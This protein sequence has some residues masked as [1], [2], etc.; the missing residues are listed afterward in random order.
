MP[1]T[2]GLSNSISVT[3]GTVSHAA[4]GRAAT[5][6]EAYSHAKSA[7]NTAAG[8]QAQASRDRLELSDAGQ[9]LSDAAQIAKKLHDIPDVRQD[10]IDNARQMIESGELFSTDALRQAARNLRGFLKDGS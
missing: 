8:T 2:G 6:T 7:G 1:T 10:V 3:A 4:S 5:V 9:L